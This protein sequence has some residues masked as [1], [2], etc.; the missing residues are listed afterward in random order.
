MNMT[1]FVAVITSEGDMIG[2]FG[3]YETKKEAIDKLVSWYE[4]KFLDII[5]EKNTTLVLEKEKT[6][7][8]GL[9]YGGR[10]WPDFDEKEFYDFYIE[11]ISK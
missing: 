4:T 5:D 1:N 2:C 7:L 10:A 8:V 6:D 3:P 9:L 11:E